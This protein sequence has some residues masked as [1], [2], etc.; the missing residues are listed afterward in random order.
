VRQVA[1][2]SPVVDISSCKFRDQVVGVKAAT[3]DDPAVFTPSVDSW[4]ARVVPSV[5]MSPD[6]QKFDHDIPTG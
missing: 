4:I 1:T 3:L 2:S 6:T 5:S